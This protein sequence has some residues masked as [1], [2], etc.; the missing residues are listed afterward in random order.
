MTLSISLPS[1]AAW[2]KNLRQMEQE[3]VD[4]LSNSDAD[5]YRDNDDSAGTEEEIE[6]VSEDILMLD[7]GEK[8]KTTCLSSTCNILGLLMYQPKLRASKLAFFHPKRRIAQAPNGKV[9]LSLLDSSI[10]KF[11]AVQQSSG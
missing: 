2:H 11:Q 4:A 6:M 3:I 8:D 9:H 7:D 1:A 5:A 10:K